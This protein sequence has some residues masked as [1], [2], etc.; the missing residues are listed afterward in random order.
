ML[1]TL[2]EWQFLSIMNRLTFMLITL[3]EWQFLSIMNRLRIFST[4]ISGILG[5]LI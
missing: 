1:I 2:Q 5:G 4:D 3:Q